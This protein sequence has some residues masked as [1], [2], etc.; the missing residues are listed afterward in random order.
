MSRH[1]NR[2][3]SRALGSL[4]EVSSVRETMG[5]VDGTMDA[6]SLNRMLIEGPG[7]AQKG[8]VG[9]I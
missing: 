7:C 5:D 2:T 9:S 4:K 3:F 1:G 6:F 8:Y